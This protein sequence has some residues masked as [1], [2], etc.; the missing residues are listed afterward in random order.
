MRNPESTGFR[1]EITDLLILEAID[2]VFGDRVV[3]GGVIPF[4]I[5]VIAIIVTE[6]LLSKIYAMLANEPISH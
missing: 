4:I 6:T 3:F 2:V 5:V 1:Y